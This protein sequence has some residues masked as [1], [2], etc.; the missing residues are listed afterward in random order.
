MIIG[1]SAAFL[2]IVNGVDPVKSLFRGVVV[3][4]V[5]MLI[6]LAVNYIYLLMVSSISK[7]ELEERRIEAERIAREREE[8]RKRRMEE[9]AKELENTSA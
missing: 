5:V 1:L 3:Y 2:G 4:S 6:L 9:A 8:A 7:K